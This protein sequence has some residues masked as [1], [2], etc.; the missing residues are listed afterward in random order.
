MMHDH[1]Y[2]HVLIKGGTSTDWASD[3]SP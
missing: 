3:M 1:R 2:N